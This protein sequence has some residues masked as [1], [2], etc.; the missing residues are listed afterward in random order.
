M[1]TPDLTTL[2][3]VPLL[4]LGLDRLTELRFSRS[5]EAATD[6]ESIFLEVADRLGAPDPDNRNALLAANPAGTVTLG[7]GVPFVRGELGVGS[8]IS[9]GEG[10][11]PTT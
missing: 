9:P 5:A 7:G 8:Y 11:I 3:D 1:A 10:A 2:N 4:Q 6:I